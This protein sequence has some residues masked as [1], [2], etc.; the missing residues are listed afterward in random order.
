MMPAFCACCSTGVNA[1]LAG[2]V[3]MAPF[4]LAVACWICW[5]IF[6]A[7]RVPPV[8]P[9]SVNSIPRLLASL[10]MQS[11]IVRHAGYCG[12][13][14]TNSA[15]VKGPVVAALVAFVFDVAPLGFAEQ[16]ARTASM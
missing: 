10:A 16:A 7:S 1:S 9:L 8:G 12:S 6:V 14:L 13:G 3:M 11:P 4:L 5:I 15:E 2:K